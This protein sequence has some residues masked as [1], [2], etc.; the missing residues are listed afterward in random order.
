M[1]MSKLRF[2]LKAMFA[3][4]LTVLD[5]WWLKTMANSHRKGNLWSTAYAVKLRKNHSF[6]GQYSCFGNKPTLPHGLSSIFISEH[7]I[8]GKNAVIYQNVTIG[9]NSMNKSKIGGGCPNNR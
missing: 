3:M 2:Y 4:P 8:I 7:A 6:I 5:W 1:E 9:S